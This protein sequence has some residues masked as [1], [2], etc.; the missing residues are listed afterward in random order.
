MR[1]ASW[2]DGLKP[3][4]PNRR[5]RRAPPPAVRRKPPARPPLSVEALDDRIVPG[6]LT[7]HNAPLVGLARSNGSLALQVLGRYPSP[8]EIRT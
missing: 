5:A 7:E 2:L 4:P 8:V 3:S 6:F 1:S